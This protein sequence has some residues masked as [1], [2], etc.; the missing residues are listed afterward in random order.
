MPATPRG[1]AIAI[2]VGVLGGG[3]LGFYYKE[4]YWAKRKEKERE[5]LECQLQKLRKERIEKEEMI[6]KKS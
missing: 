4:E 6:A 2:I 1:R 3:G 5:E